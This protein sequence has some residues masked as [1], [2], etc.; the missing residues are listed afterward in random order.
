MRGEKEQKLSHLKQSMPG[1]KIS[2]VS[3]GYVHYITLP[4]S[5]TIRKNKQ[6]QIHDSQIPEQNI[7][8]NTTTE[9][10]LGLFFSEKLLKKICVG[11]NFLTQNFIFLTKRYAV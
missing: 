11:F 5:A 2:I 1:T 8:A 9:P 3:S 6:N 7:S 10:D 4:I